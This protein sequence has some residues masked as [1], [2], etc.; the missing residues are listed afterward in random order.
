MILIVDDSPEMANVFAK[1][2]IKADFAIEIMGDG[3]QALAAL[4]TGKYELALMDILLPSISGIE[5][6]KRMREAGCNTPIIA[7]SGSIEPEST[8]F[9]AWM[10]KPLRVSELV[11]LVKQYVNKDGDN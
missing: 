9:V 6:A 2:L 1:A 4:L 11:D 8:D 5:V 3:K 10:G 7:I